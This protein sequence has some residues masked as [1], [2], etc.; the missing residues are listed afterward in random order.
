MTQIDL[1]DC[2]F[3]F[4][5]VCAPIYMSLHAENLIST[6]YETFKLKLLQYYIIVLCHC[7]FTGDHEM[8]HNCT[9]I[10][11]ITDCAI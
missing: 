3:R 9:I 1:I 5:N 4:T 6:C 7:L 11:I 10:N 8:K 2:Q